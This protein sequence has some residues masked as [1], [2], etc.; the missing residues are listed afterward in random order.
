[1]K[2]M[3]VFFIMSIGVLILTGCTSGPKPPAEERKIENVVRVLMHQP[4]DY[5]IFSEPKNLDGPL[6][7]E[8]LRNCSK[9]H[10]FLDVPADKPMFA[11]VTLDYWDGIEEWKPYPAKLELHLHSATD[12]NGAGW[13]HGKHGSG[14]TTV[15][16]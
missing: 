2:G 6:D 16:Q 1:M 15:V 10:I 12:I 7:E 3:R 11:L 8:R 14:T 13:N 5:T 4:K 9:V